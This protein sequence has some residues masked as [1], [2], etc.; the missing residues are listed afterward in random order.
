MA[1]KDIAGRLAC[2]AFDLL[3][4]TDHFWSWSQTDDNHILENKSDSSENGAPDGDNVNK[5]K[6]NYNLKMKLADLRNWWNRFV[7]EEN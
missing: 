7:E 5:N 4:N 6:S 3:G 2:Q 1:E